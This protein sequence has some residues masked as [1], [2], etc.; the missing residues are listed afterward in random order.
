[1]AILLAANVADAPGVQA[2]ASNIPLDA[3]AVN[4]ADICCGD[5]PLAVNQQHGGQG[6]TGQALAAVWSAS[7]TR[8]VTA[9]FAANGLTSVQPFS[10]MEVPMTVKPRR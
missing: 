10:S 4:E 6:V 8:Q 7:N 9:F 5:A 1:V 2:V 3:A